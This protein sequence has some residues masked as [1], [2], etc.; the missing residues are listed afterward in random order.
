MEPGGVEQ[1]VTDRAA[2]EAQRCALLLLVH[3]ACQRRGC[4][5][6]SSRSQTE[7]QEAALLLLVHMVV[8][9]ADEE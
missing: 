8:K 5:A 6:W 7:P 3:I 1:Q 2:Q 4:P 9:G